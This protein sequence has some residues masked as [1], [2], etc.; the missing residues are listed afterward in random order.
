ME[1][2]SPKISV[3]IVTYNRYKYLPKSLNSVLNQTFQHYEVIL[4]DNGS[5]DNTNALCEDYSERDQRIKLITIPKNNGASQGRNAGIDAA[6]CEYITIVDDDDFCESEMLE[7]LYMNAD[8][9]NADISICGSWNDFGNRLEPYFIFDELLILDKVKSLD[10][11]LKREKYN[12]APPTKLFRRK[13][14]EGIRFIDGVLVDD[15]HIIYKVFANANTVVASGKPLYHFMK[16]DGNMTG[17][18]QSN[19][20]TPALLDEYLYMYSERTKYLSNR[21]P[22]IL[23]RARCS[24]WAY[25]ISMCDKIK[26]Y[27]CKECNKQYMQMI[28]N[29][30]EN[31]KEFWDSPFINERERELIKKHFILNNLIYKEVF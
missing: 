10:E 17:F 24:E 9:Y 20:L 4:V 6:S 11:L 7:H 25:M 27:N 5:T 22:E 21:V 19:K 14:F 30:Y 23:S 2:I 12:V 13:L 1:N 8:K 16:H 29:V 3:I 15:I 26:T 31:I 28:N 18:I